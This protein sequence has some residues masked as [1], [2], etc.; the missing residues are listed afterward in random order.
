[1][2]VETA[3]ASG[4]APAFGDDIQIQ[5]VVM[6]LA[7]NAIDAMLAVPGGERTLRIEAAPSGEGG[8]EV[9][10]ADRGPGIADDDRE[11]VYD[12]F[13][14]T[15]GTGLGIGLSICRTIVEAHGGR[16]WHDRNPGGGTVFRFTLPDAS[17]GA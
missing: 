15:K 14:T 8:V 5:Q 13:Y 10:V 1:V 12:P 6:N 4:L 7:H 17:D 3:V 11:K 2:R 9:R 16:L